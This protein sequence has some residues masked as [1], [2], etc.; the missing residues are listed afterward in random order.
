M[1]PKIE[2]SGAGTNDEKQSEFPP[3]FLRWLISLTIVTLLFVF[4]GDYIFARHEVRVTPVPWVVAGGI[5]I[6]QGLDLFSGRQLVPQRPLHMPKERFELSGRRFLL[7]DG[8]IHARFRGFWQPYSRRNR[9]Q[10]IIPIPAVRPECV[11]WRAQ[12]ASP[13]LGPSGLSAQCYGRFSRH[14]LPRRVHSTP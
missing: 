13:E 1:N 9:T 4:L 10:T 11:S 6:E 14:R 12:S 2:V 3:M 7:R 8:T 5:V